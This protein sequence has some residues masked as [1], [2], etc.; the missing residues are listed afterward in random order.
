MFELAGQ[1][2][3][4][5]Y[6]FE[7][8][9]LTEAARRKLPINM[10]PIQTIYLEDNNSS[11][12]RAVRDSVLIYQR[13]LKYLVTALG[14]FVLDICLFVILSSA[15]FS[16][17]PSGVWWSNTLARCGSGFF[18]FKLNQLWSFQVK[19]RKTVQFW[20]YLLLFICV[21]QISSALV[22]LCS[23]L[24]LPLPLSK[25]VID[26]VLFFVNYYVQKHWVFVE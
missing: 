26:T 2:P 6:D 17:S 10:L 1:T 11:H 3:G 7:M 12:F 25:A 5:R 18:N 9:F 24:P 20:K 22:S 8:N 4:E 23:G 13:P 14:S 19:E 15:I 16:A 21:M